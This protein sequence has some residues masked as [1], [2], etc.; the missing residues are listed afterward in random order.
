MSGKTDKKFIE[1]VWEYYRQNGRHTLPWRKTKDPYKIVVS[2][3]MLQQTQVERVLPKYKSFIKK[4]GSVEKLS[5][6]SL[7][8]VLIEWQGLGYNRRARMLHECG[9]TLVEKNGTKFPKEYNELIKLPGIGPYTA[10]AVMAF[11]FNKPVPILE[12]NIRTV[13]LHHFFSGETNVTDRELTEVVERTLDVKNPR[14]WYWALMDYGSYLKRRIGNQNAKAK[15]YSRQSKFKGSDREIRGAIIRELAKGALTQ[16]KIEK[17][18]FTVE[19]IRE[20]LQKLLQE[21]M[22]EQKR[23]RYSLPGK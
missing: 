15:S 11:A 6:A 4:W 16:T 8:D 12:T 23:G 13:Y 9:K 1:T 21:Q 20:Q 10:G 19:R 22:I 18:P 17:L 3:I 14:E 2:E 5:Q 7:A